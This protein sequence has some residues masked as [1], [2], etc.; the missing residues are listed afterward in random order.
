M[1]Y[2][3]LPAHDITA[4]PEQKEPNSGTALQRL[5]TRPRNLLAISIAG[6]LAFIMLYLYLFRRSS[7][8]KLENCGTSPAEAVA[9]GCSFDIMSFAWLPARCFDRELMEDF[10][11]LRRWEWFMD[12]EGVGIADVASVFAGS[13]DELYVTEEYHLYHCT[14][15]W[16]KMHRAVLGGNPL[17]SYIGNIKHTE[18]CE[19][20]L[21]D[22]E[23]PLDGITTRIF[24]KYPNCPGI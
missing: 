11:A 13:Y 3:V 20:M 6:V 7:H 17:D 2:D 23:R 12:N 8:S 18:H 5:W 4:E 9:L 15:M 10:L 1:P 19:M 21:I 16:K 14:Y 24:T 22:K